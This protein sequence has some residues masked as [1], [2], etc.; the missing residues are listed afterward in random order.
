MRTLAHVYEAHKAIPMPERGVNA[1][2]SGR[3]KAFDYYH[4]VLR[5]YAKQNGLT[6]QRAVALFH[7]YLVEQTLAQTRT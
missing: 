4:R 5:A 2:D 6:L 7:T 3:I 1:K